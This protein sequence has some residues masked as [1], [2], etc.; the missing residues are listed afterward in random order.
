M[1]REGVDLEGFVML[2][3]TILNQTPAQVKDKD[4]NVGITLLCQAFLYSSTSSKVIKSIVCK[5]NNTVHQMM[6]S[7]YTLLFLI[8]T[9]PHIRLQQVREETKE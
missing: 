9:R 7:V 4:G 2:L 1:Q 5:H 3:A 6:R 8:S